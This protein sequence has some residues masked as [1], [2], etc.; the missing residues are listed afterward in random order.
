MATFPLLST[1]AVTQYPSGATDKFATEVMQFVDGSEQRFRMLKTP[2]R[3]WSIRLGLLTDREMEAVEQ[4]C[5]DVQF[6]FGSF[7]FVDPWDGTEYVDCSLD[8][9]AITSRASGPIRYE[10]NLVIRR[11]RP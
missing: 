2:Q 6:E 5:R 11:N 9:A 8:G 4:F 10:T 3:S 7:T 1:G